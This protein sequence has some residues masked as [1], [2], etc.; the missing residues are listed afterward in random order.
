MQTIKLL[1][2]T[3]VP[4]SLKGLLKGPLGFLNSNA[5]EVV[6][7]SSPCRENDFVRENEGVEVK[8]EE[9]SR[10]K[11]YHSLNILKTKWSSLYN[12]IHIFTLI[13]LMHKNDIIHAHLFTFQFYVW[14]A[15]ILSFSKAKIIYRIQYNQ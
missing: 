3:T 11:I 7:V 10:V 13:K 2:I 1:R 15:K 12:P 9:L 4:Q 8:V 5:F 14:I 6:G